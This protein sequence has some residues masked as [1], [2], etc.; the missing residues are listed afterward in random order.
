MDIFYPSG[1][2]NYDEYFKVVLSIAGVLLGLAFA[3]LLFVIQSGFTSFKYSRRMFLELYVHFG[4][5]LL[6][7]L[8]YLTLM[9]LLVLYVSN[10]WWVI[11]IS[12]IVFS[13]SY[14]RSVLNHKS[15][16]GYIHTINSDKFVPSGY[17]RI[18]KY[19][20]YIR[21]LGVIHSLFLVT[22]L[23]VLLGYP[24]AVSIF[25]VNQVSLTEKGIFYSTLFVL[26]LSIIKITN[27]IP[28][29]FKLSNQELE[30]NSGALSD[31]GDPN[32][33]YKIEKEAFEKYAVAHGISEIDVFKK[34]KFLDGDLWVQILNSKKAEVWC[35]IP[36]KNK[37][38]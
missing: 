28:E 20:R 29:F 27:F 37:R 3:A 9:P 6:I 31:S 2:E 4:N 24:L 33:D 14:S 32:M 7:S 17:G 26:V 15:H 5:G 36:P 38:V 16:V 1:I 8:A 10:H 13:Y 25:E 12:Y 11:N 34:T 19:F 21:N 22:T 23:L 30:S 35:V 18:R